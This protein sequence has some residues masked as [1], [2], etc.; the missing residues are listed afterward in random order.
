MWPGALLGV[1]MDPD[2]AEIAQLKAKS[3]WSGIDWRA[4][5]VGLPDASGDYP[6]GMD[7]ARW[8]AFGT[9][10]WRRT[11]SEVAQRVLAV[12][13][14]PGDPGQ[15]TSPP[16]MIALDEV[17]RSS[18]QVDVLKVD[19]DGHDLEV[20]QSGPR[21]LE[22]ALSVDVEVQFQGS[23]HPRANTF[24]N[25]DRLLREAGFELFDVRPHRHSRAILPAPFWGSPGSPTRTGQ[26]VWGQA[27][28]LRDVVA[29]PWEGLG[30]RGWILAALF[31]LGGLPDCAAELIENGLVP[32]AGSEEIAVLGSGW[33]R[34][35]GVRAR[36]LLR[37]DP[38]KLMLP[39]LPRLRDR[40]RRFPIEHLWRPWRG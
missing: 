16:P 11:S 20:L 22:T 32:G 29:S 26:T 13:V 6:E 8:R 18:P 37:T 21:A 12:A 38:T 25:I 35:G 9:R 40:I 31:E 1:G 39:G 4:G 7:R 3:Q 28:Y 14:P 24:S 33:W 15:Q 2:V 10:T 27:L 36:R 23:A 19:T 5:W 17:F 34:D 30:N